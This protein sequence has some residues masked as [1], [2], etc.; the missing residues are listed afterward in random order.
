MT[1][2]RRPIIEWKQARERTL[3]EG[4]RTEVGLVLVHG[5]AKV[6]ADAALDDVR[7]PHGVQV[8]LLPVELD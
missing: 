1:Q 2:G 8:V 5:S 6:V 7:V 4:K 3:S